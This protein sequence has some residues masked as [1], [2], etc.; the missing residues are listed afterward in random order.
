MSTRRVLKRFPSEEV[1]KSLKKSRRALRPTSS[2]TDSRIESELN[3]GLHLARNE[4]DGH[5][6]FSGPVCDKVAEESQTNE[7]QTH[8]E[9]GRT[10]EPQQVES[11]AQTLEPQTEVE[12]CTQIEL[13]NLK[14]DI[15]QFKEKDSDIAFYKGFP[16][17]K[18]L[19]VKVTPKSFFF[20]HC[21]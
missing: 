13:I 17:Y 4:Q 19:K 3:I 1:K 9:F 11:G 21:Q 18:I 12:F 5:T 2:A 15:D 7:M 16:N 8:V 20:C 14:F 6:D 10:C